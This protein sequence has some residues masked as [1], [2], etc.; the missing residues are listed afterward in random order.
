M[1]RKMIKVIITIIP[2][3]IVKI[4]SNI[5]NLNNEDKKKQIVNIY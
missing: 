4:N 1:N 3:T 5:K 2:V